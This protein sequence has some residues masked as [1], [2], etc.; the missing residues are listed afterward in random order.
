MPISFTSRKYRGIQ[1]GQS[2]T[3]YR[4]G[5]A[6][7]RP[8]TYYERNTDEGPDARQREMVAKLSR[9][10]QQIRTSDRSALGK[11]R[12]SYG[13]T[14]DERG[15]VLAEVFAAAGYAAPTARDIALA[16]NMSNEEI[17]ESVL[18]EENPNGPA[19]PEAPVAGGDPR[20]S[21][22]PIIQEGEPP[23][24]VSVNPIIEQPSPGDDPR[25]STG[26]ILQEG[27]PPAYTSPVEQPTPP[28]PPPPPLYEPAPPPGSPLYGGFDRREEQGYELRG[29]ATTLYPDPSGNM[30]ADPPYVEPVVAPPSGSPEYGSFD[31]A[32]VAGDELRSPYTPDEQSPPSWDTYIDPGVSAPE[33]TPV[34]VYDEDGNLVAISGDG[35]EVTA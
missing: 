3:G 14:S 2:I 30:V 8:A 6:R 15:A 18:P 17:V 33:P 25:V 16:A 32:E 22:G 27:P 34:Y 26:P 12:D 9:L 28:P 20:V 19:G 10:E 21:T 4:P 5:Q 29:P 24:P 11:P 1:Y 35:G 23:V 13:R 7:I 31:P